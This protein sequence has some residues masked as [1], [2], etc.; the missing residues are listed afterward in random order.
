MARPLDKFPLAQGQARYPW[1]KWLDGR[2][3]ELIPDED[4][5]GNV[6]TFTTNARHQARKRGGRLRTR[7]PKEGV[8]SNLVIQFRRD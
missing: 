2:P 3:W 4:F 6:S 1:D 7:L 5:R 8:M